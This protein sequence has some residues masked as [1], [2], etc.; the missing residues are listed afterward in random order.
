MKF[1]CSVWKFFDSIF[2]QEEVQIMRRI[3][4]MTVICFFLA[5][6]VI[7]QCWAGLIDHERL[8]RRRGLPL[9][10]EKAQAAKAK[11]AEV[12]EAKMELPKWITEPPVVKGSTDRKYDVNND[13]KLQ[14]SEVTI[15]LRDVL[16]IVEEKGGYQVDSDMLKEY[17]K[18]RDGL[19]T[20]V[21][22]IQIREH[23]R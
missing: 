20:K 3:S 22:A 2:S 19:L 21:E 1:F 8:N 7:Q 23:V 5:S 16:D 11:A 15:L 13:G 4:I 14:K 9:S 17:D 10:N 12:P 6:L 18:N